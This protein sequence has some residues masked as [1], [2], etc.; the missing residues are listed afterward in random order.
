M[1]PKKRGRENGRRRCVVSISLDAD[2]LACLD[3]LAERMRV[4]LGWKVSRSRAVR[5]L[6]TLGGMIERGEQPRRILGR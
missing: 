6:I 2:G 1:Q 3:A 4:H 5:H